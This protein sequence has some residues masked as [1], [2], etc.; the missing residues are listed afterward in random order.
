MLL[1]VKKSEQ[2]YNCRKVRKVLL[3]VGRFVHQK[4]HH[5][6]I[7]IFAGFL[8]EEPKA[9]L[10]L[11]GEG[12]LE[13]EIRKQVNALGDSWNMCGFLG[14]R[15]D[16]P[17]LMSASDLFLLPSHYEGLPVVGVEAQANGLPCC[18]S[19]V[20]TQEIDLINGMNRFVDLTSTETEWSEAL[21]HVLTAKKSARERY[22]EK[23]A[24][25]GF[26]LTHVADELTQFY[27]SED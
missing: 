27:I 15:K 7:K 10:L 8:K 26:S 13:E 12:E 1:T 22:A 23:I 24:E 2:N 17:Q 25:K 11:V 20:I 3:H 6:L 19:S 18:F 4:N 9:V 16:I 14:V 21:N 5:Q